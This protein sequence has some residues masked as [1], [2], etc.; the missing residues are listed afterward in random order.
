MTYTAWGLI[1]FQLVGEG[2]I[3][4]ADWNIPTV[5]TNESPVGHL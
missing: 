4:Q 3:S 2:F 5:M 1:T